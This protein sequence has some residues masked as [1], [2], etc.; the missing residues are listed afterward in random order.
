MG[1]IE[2][3]SEGGVRRRG[4][5][6][7]SERTPGARKTV[8]GI[9]GAEG[10]IWR[11]NMESQALEPTAPKCGRPRGWWRGWGGV[12]GRETL[13]RVKGRAA[14]RAG[15]P[16]A[17]REAIAERTGA[18]D[19]WGRR[20]P[21]G[22]N[23][24]R[25]QKTAPGPDRPSEAPEQAGDRESV[26]GGAANPAWKKEG[27]ASLRLGGSQHIEDSWLLRWGAG[28]CRLEHGARKGKGGPFRREISDEQA[29]VR[30]WLWA[31]GKDGRGSNIVWEGGPPPGWVCL[32]F[33]HSR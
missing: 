19:C 9:A 8:V 20:R 21:R 22:D 11:T 12:G 2:K 18:Q 28:G 16:K 6:G 31:K 26:W 1:R 3:S 33:Q 27:A 4:L 32:F 15:G 10:Q 7:F 23:G 25:V 17:H 29:P 30:G 5:S 14:R 13:R 24:R